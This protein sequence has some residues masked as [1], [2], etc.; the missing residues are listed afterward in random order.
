MAVYT[1]AISRAGQSLAGGNTRLR[2]VWYL[3][4]PGRKAYAQ[5]PWARIDVAAG[6]RYAAVLE[7]YP[8]RRV[9]VVATT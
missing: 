1:Y 8:A 2:N 6:G 3:Y 4:D 5:T 7:S 9:G